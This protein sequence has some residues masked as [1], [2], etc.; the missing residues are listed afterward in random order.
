MITNADAKNID[1]LKRSVIDQL[2]NSI[3]YVRTAQPRK[4]NCARDAFREVQVQII[5]FC[6]LAVHT[7]ILCEKW[8]DTEGRVMTSAEAMVEEARRIQEAEER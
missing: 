8:T 3:S 4:D 2:Q 7:A 6:N 1:H 5:G